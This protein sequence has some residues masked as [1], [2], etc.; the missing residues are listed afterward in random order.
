MILGL[1][2]EARL[3]IER[4]YYLASDDNV[5]LVAT[6]D[7]LKHV[8]ELFEPVSDLNIRESYLPWYHMRLK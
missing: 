5:F 4:F 6:V 2:F 8:S 1:K 7:N 3:T